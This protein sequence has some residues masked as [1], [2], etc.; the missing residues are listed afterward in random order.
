MRFE[1]CCIQFDLYH[2]SIIIILILILI[3][4]LN[5]NHYNS[6]PSLSSPRSRLVGA[7]RPSIHT[8]S[9]RR[10]SLLGRGAFLTVTSRAP[11]KRPTPQLRTEHTPAL[12]AA[13]IRTHTLTPLYPYTPSMHLQLR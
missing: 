12:A 4:N 8:T 6:S 5:L 2:Y 11:D 13:T 9:S 7:F 10:S 3:L 1:S